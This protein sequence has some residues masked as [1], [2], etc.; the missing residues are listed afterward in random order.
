[1]VGT[2]GSTIVSYTYPT[3]FITA[4]KTLTM[5]RQKREINEQIYHR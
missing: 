4:H 3:T 5:A 2:E 1:M